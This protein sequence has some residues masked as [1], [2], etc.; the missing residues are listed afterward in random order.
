MLSPGEHAA[1]VAG[2]SS[3]VRPDG[4]GYAESRPAIVTVGLLPS[5]HGSAQCLLGAGDPVLAIARP[6]AVLVGVRGEPVHVPSQPDGTGP[7]PSLGPGPGGAHPAGRGGALV[8]SVSPVASGSVSSGGG[9]EALAGLAAQ[10]EAALRPCLPPLGPVHRAPGMEPGLAWALNVAVTVVAWNGSVL[11]AA[12][13]AL[14][15]ALGDLTVPQ[16]TVDLA[17]TL[18][19]QPARLRLDP[20]APRRRLF[21]AGQL[22]QIPIAVSAV[23]I[24]ETWVVDPT[25]F[26]ELQATSRAVALACAGR[27]P[28]PRL[29]ALSSHSPVPVPLQSLAGTLDLLLG[30]AARRAQSRSRA[31]PVQGDCSA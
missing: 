22:A 21:S 24:H 25:E 26:E 30:L 4:R 12:A 14:H 23:C 9:G 16:V 27:G 1:V 11:D 13:V 17:Q 31:P 15:A 10:L 2:L 18:P 8:V 3:G 5:A 29:I 19:G 6:T 20:A 7:S 28:V